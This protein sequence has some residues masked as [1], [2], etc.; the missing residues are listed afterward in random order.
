MSG[1][2]LPDGALTVIALGAH[3][4]DI[5]IG[6]GGT[7]LT[8]LRREGVSVRTLVLTGTEE[9]RAE[10][11]AAASAVGAS[12][13]P[14]FGGFP[15]ARLP[16]HWGA[17]K[18]TLHAFRDSGGTPDL[19]FAPRPDDAHQDHAL[20]GS[21]V[22]TVW[23]GPLILHYEIPKWD[24]DAGRPNLYVPLTPE[25]AEEKIRLLNESFPSQRGRGWWDDELFSSML[26]LRGME[27]GSRSAEA[28]RVDKATL[29]IGGTP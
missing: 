3:P 14:V 5:E 6:C 27:C 7:L 29:A 22:S 16:E 8:L 9:R 24:G 18:D 13:P 28:F 19:I 17:V 10:A 11:E 21:M 25:T 26:R 4:D 23:R 2:V 1:L 15:D 20:L 12:T